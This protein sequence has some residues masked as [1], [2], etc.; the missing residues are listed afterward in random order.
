MNTNLSRLFLSIPYL[1]PTLLSLLSGLLSSSLLCGSSLSLSLSLSL[2]VCMCS[3]VKMDSSNREKSNVCPRSPIRSAA[4]GRTI[5]SPQRRAW[6]N[7]VGVGGGTIERRHSD[8]KLLL[9]FFNARV[10]GEKKAK[11]KG[12]S[13]GYKGDGGSTVW[14]NIKGKK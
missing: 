13:V 1:L 10:K 12:S 4:K 11:I 8:L 6:G 14:F 2:C 5:S 7:G 3:F 9:F